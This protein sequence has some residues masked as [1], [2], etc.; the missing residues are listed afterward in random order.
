MQLGMQGTQEVWI[1]EYTEV[2]VCVLDLSWNPDVQS[3]DS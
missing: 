3:L 2:N 1:Q